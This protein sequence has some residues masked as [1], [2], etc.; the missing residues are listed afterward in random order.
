MADC[1]IVIDD[2]VDVVDASLIAGGSIWT[3]NNI[4]RQDTVC[5][6]H[7]HVNGLV[8]ANRLLL[9]RTGGADLTTPDA[10]EAAEV[11]DLRPDQ[12]LAAYGRGAGQATPRPAYQ[13]DLP[14]Q[15]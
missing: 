3:C 2:P 11:F 12:L 8:Q 5:N 15:Y 4:A 7:L 6:V 13:I 14:P 1:D 10:R 9:W